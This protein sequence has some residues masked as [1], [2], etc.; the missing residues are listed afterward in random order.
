MDRHKVALFCTT[1]G[2]QLNHANLNNRIWRPA[3]KKANIPYRPMIQTRHSFAA[4]AL[5]LGEDPLRI[6]HVM[7]HRDIDM[8]VKV[9]TKYLKNPG[10]NNNE[11]ALNT[12]LTGTIGNY[13]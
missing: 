13:N 8:I 5:S 4:T 2:G 1:T 7:G 3:L 9:Y 10:N 12:R 6:A 11:K